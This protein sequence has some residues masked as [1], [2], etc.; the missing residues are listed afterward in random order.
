M[1]THEFE[2][3][4]RLPELRSCS[5]HADTPGR[6]RRGVNVKPN[7]EERRSLRRA[8]ATTARTGAVAAAMGVATPALAAD[9]L[10]LEPNPPILGA[11]IVGFVL[12]IFPANQLI[13][14]PIFRALDEREERIQGARNRASQIQRDADGVLSDYETRIREA[15]FDADTARKDAIAAARGEQTTMTAG[16]RSE[17]EAEIERARA[18]LAGELEDARVQ[19][20]ADAQE[21]ARA[22][23]AQILGRSLS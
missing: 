22:A 6:R 12:L 20:R 3:R 2:T 1:T 17:A 15:R 9:A 21:L 11:L 10:V 7:M 23:A 18:A 5:K 4:S 13:F 16:A 14:K 19:M 8:V